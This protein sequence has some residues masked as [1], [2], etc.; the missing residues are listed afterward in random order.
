MTEGHQQERPERLQAILDSLT[1]GVVVANMDGELLHWNRAWLIM[2]GFLSPDETTR[3]L[4]DLASVIE[5]A[6]P[7]GDIIPLAHWPLSRVI[8]GEDVDE[9]D[10]RCRRLDRPWERIFR[11]RGST[12]PEADGTRLAMLSITD[13][14][15]RRRADAR[16][17]LVVDASP[18]GMIVVD[19]AGVIRIA[20]AEVERL[21]GWPRDELLG[22]PVERLLPEA[23]R[24]AHRADREAYVQAPSRR[25]MASGRELTGLHRDGTRFPIEVALNPFQLHDATAVLAVIADISE[26]RSAAMARERHQRELE[27]SNRELAQF[28]YV[29]SHDL[30]EP[31]RMVASYTELFAER[32]RPL[33]D[34][35][36]ERYV[37]Y[38]VDG[39]RRMQQLVR[40]LLTYAQV[41]S[42]GRPLARVSA[43]DVLAATLHD[44]SAT[45][46]ETG[47]QVTSDP[48]PEIW[49][50]AGQL[51]QLFLNLITNALKFRRDVPPVVHIAAERAGD[52]WTFAVRDNGIGIAREYFE[53]IFAMFQRL[54]TRDDYAG[55][56]IGLSIARRIVERHGGELWVDSIEG[57]GTTMYCR[58]LAA[59]RPLPG[60]LVAPRATDATRPRD[61]GSVGTMSHRP[62]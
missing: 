24:E 4:P 13:V 25:S 2:H 46:A 23:L 35:R 43:S 8:R 41:G 56:G 50:D 16:F 22:Q 9:V 17:R 39:A 36:G 28:A 54:H 14:T 21:F 5:L 20:N 62:A 44:L 59:D 53:R 60:E 40:D 26:R 34:E 7:D 42:Q 48:L 51:Q 30:Q 27:R 1:E 11:Y 12:V 47:A 49:A 10:L 37:H 15:E 38:I 3:R 45:I 18:I 55:S 32:Y 29:A 57:E 31:L 58:L 61:R 52:H 33:L 6:T 19:A